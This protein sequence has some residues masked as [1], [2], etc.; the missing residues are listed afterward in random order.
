[1]VIVR[2]ESH[3]GFY[4]E[5]V[6]FPFELLSFNCPA[7][8]ELQVWTHGIGG[9]EL[10]DTVPLRELLIESPIGSPHLERLGRGLNLFGDDGIEAFEA[11]AG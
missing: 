3:N 1:M 5:R 7:E 10:I 4:L 2:C 6:V 11:A 9:P 8:G